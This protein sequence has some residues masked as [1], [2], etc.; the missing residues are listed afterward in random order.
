MTR[1]HGIFFHAWH[2]VFQQVQLQNWM[3]NIVAGIIVF[4]TV[5]L[6]WP[7]VRHAMERFAK[8]HFESLKAEIHE[9]LDAQHV[10]KMAQAER[11]HQEKVTQAE[12]HH[13][14]QLAAIRN[15]KETK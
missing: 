11:H 15:A 14:S 12:R 10:E 13:K 9:K 5:S 7:K 2:F 3:G 8:R 1:L 6:F 4:C